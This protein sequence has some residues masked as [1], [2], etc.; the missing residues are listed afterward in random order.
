MNIQSTR[1]VIIL[2]RVKQQFDAMRSETK[3]KIKTAGLQLFAYKGLAATSIQD[4]ATQAGI[5]VGLMYHY[6]KSKED[7]FDELA[8]TAVELASE[9]MQMI[10][11][12]DQS[13]AE[14]FKI[15]SRNVT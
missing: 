4:I 8:E 1:R 5:S 6:Y 2:P 12:S 13:P 15:F 11:N 10:F 7:L 9:S 3:E 14:K